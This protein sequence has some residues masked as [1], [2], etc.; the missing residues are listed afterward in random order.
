MTFDEWQ[1]LHEKNY[2]VKESVE[3]DPYT[4]NEPNNYLLCLLYERQW[5]KCW[6]AKMRKPQAN[7]K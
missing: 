2:D 4:L 5:A 6:S 1:L 3:Q 7:V